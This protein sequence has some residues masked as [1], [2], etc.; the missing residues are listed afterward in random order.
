L[1]VLTAS[2]RRL[3]ILLDVR[4]SICCFMRN[5]KGEGWHP[6]NRFNSA[7]FLHPS[8]ATT[9][10]SNIVCRSWSCCVC[11]ASSVK[12]RGDCWFSCYWWCWWP[13]LFKLSFYKKYNLKSVCWSFPLFLKLK[14]GEHILTLQNLVTGYKIKEEYDDINYLLT[15]IGFSIYKTIVLQIK[16]EKYVI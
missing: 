12:M 14:L 1:S 13:S 9:W 16:G 10:I 15:I 4:V 2:I 5:N 7:T 3:V 6:I 8:Q 11:S